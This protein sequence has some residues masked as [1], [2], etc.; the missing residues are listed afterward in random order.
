[1]SLFCNFRIRFI[2][3]IFTLLILHFF[4]GQ[5]HLWQTIF[6][7]LWQTEGNFSW[8]KWNRAKT[9]IYSINIWFCGILRYLANMFFGIRIPL[10]TGG[11]AAFTILNFR[12]KQTSSPRGL[13]F[14]RFDQDQMHNCLR[15]LSWSWQLLD[16]KQHCKPP[17]SRK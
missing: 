2:Q 15:R 7:I 13:L 14:L 3:I 5:L 8:I 17:I 10:Y 4:V 1:M 11:Y 6:S 12:S 9:S 16:K